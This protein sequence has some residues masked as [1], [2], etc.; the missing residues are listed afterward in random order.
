MSKSYPSERIKPTRS[1]AWAKS[2]LSSRSGRRVAAQGEHVFD[3]AFPQVGERRPNGRLVRID[4]GDVGERL[5]AEAFH[6]GRNFA[7][8]RIART[9][10]AARD[11]NIVGMQ[12]G[13]LRNGALNGGR[14]G[15]GLGG[16]DLKGPN[17][18]FLSENGGNFHI[19]P[20][21]GGG[22]ARPRI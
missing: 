15:R 9:A 2:L 8:A 13:K 12:G 18:L 5:H 6:Q 14:V 7:R 21:F 10:R 11:G 16:K 1:E 4:A 17:R 3:A 19:F 22:A 20:F